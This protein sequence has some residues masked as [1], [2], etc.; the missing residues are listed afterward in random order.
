L[1][2]T[3]YLFDGLAARKIKIVLKI[4]NPLFLPF[5]RSHP[6][7]NGAQHNIM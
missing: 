2:V 7:E 5:L 3:N 4:N 1:R 6:E